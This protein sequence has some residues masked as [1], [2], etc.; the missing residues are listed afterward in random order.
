MDELLSQQ[1]KQ[2]KQHQMI[3]QFIQRMEQLA[4]QT[5]LAAQQVN[6]QVQQTQQLFQQAIQ[7]AHNNSKNRNSQSLDENNK[8][9]PMN[10]NL[11]TTN[12]SNL[13]QSYI[14]NS[15][16]IGFN[17][18]ALQVIEDQN[19]RNLY[20][21]ATQYAQDTITQLEGMFHEM[22]FPIPI[23]FTEADV[24]LKAP[25]LFTDE[26]L[27]YFLHTMTAN[28]MVGYGLSLSTSVGKQVRELN[29][30]GYNHSIELY[31]KSLELMLSLKLF[32]NFPQ[33]P[34]PTTP[35]FVHEQGFILNFTKDQKRPLDILEISS[36][37]ANLKTVIM[38]KAIAIAFSQVANLKEVRMV[39][40]ENVE[41]LEKSIEEFASL[42]HNDFLTSLRLW[43]TNITNSN[44]PPYSDRLMLTLIAAL[45]SLSVSNFGSSLG[46]S[47]RIDLAPMYATAIS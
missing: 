9:K 11:V 45:I 23:G 46:V 25:R 32:D 7:L 29:K 5:Q 27:L 38:H 43:D 21:R 4:Q 47:T 40:R 22:D 37:F 34:I 15:L 26:F 14:T 8:Q 28:G 30:N 20:E 19:I 39:L 3:K 35:E 17:A 2:E 33:V 1:N 24:N 42:L 18:H 16:Y 41:T 36:L 6:E 13:W 44:I 12:I 31:E 10:N